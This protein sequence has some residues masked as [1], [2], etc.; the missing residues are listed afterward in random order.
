MSVN[1][2][3]FCETSSPDPK[4]SPLNPT[5]GLA[6]PDS[7]GYN[8]Q[9]TIPGAVTKPYDVFLYFNQR[10][11]CRSYS[12]TFFICSVNKKILV[13]EANQYPSRAD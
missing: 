7:L 13:Y 1:C 8:P 12:Y 3:S 9:M 4:A 2:F 5:G 10:N 6:S 11:K